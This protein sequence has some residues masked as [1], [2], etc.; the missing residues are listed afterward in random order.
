MNDSIDG[1]EARGVEVREARAADLP[2]LL[3]CYGE[4]HP[5]DPEVDAAT[6]AAIW[7]EISTQAGRTVLVAARGDALGGTVDCLL[8]PNLTRGGRPFMFVENVVV[9]NAYRR[10]GVGSLLIGA[11][12]ARAAE[13]GCY[14]VQLL[15]RASRTDAHAFYEACGFGP[16]AQGYRRYLP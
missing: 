5:D 1:G 12:L 7:R 4:L 2:E 15:S 8:V 3:A 11:A 14:K 9:R 10:Q 6:A 13:A 16:S